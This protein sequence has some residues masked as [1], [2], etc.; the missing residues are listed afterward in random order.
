MPLQLS[1]EQGQTLDRFGA[2]LN[3]QSRANETDPNKRVICHVRDKATGQLY[4][5][6]YT[7][8]GEQEAANAAIDALPTAE[9]PLT[10]AQRL[11]ESNSDLTATIAAKDKEIAELHAKL[12]AATT[13][14]ETPEQHAAAEDK[15]DQVG[16]P[17]KPVQTVAAVDTK[18][19][20][21]PK[22]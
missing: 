18:I 2:E 19:S 3:F 15:I 5:D 22:K 16:P 6:R 14:A 7:G 20:L 12:A 21:K 17:D 1:P 13:T 9:K 8:P 11:T 10:A 4:K